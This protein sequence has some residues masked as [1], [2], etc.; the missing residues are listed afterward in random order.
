MMANSPPPVGLDGTGAMNPMTHPRSPSFSAAIA[1]AR[2]EEAA[3]HRAE[4]DAVKREN[5]MLKQ[6]IRDLE[7]RVGEATRRRSSLG[8]AVAG[9]DNTGIANDGSENQVTD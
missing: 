7:R 3:F 4:L 2:Y 8:S 5:E 6:R 9:T 1:A